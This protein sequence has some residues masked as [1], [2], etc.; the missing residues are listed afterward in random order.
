M[1]GPH[2]YPSS[3]EPD[4]EIIAWKCDACDEW[5]SEYGEQRDDCTVDWRATGL[6]KIINRLA[7]RLSVDLREDA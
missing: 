7:E 5:V 1:S 4:A 3:T 2:K 6:R